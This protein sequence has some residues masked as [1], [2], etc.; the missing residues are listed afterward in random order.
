MGDLNEITLWTTQEVATQL[1]VSKRTVTRVINNGELPFIQIGRSIRVSKE[2]L[3]NFVDQQR[4]YNLGCVESALS[5]SGES[6]CDS[7][8]VEAFTTLPTNR[9]VENKLDALLTPMTNK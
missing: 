5:Q 7:I 4:R 3:F 8:N 1:N 9:E 6:L 2:D